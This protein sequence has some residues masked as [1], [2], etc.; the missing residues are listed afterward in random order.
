MKEIKPGHLLE[1]LAE[2]VSSMLIEVDGKKFV[3]ENLAGNFLFHVI[4]VELSK[5]VIPSYWEIPFLSLLYFS[6]G[7]IGR[8][9]K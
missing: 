3:A 5:S 7:L 6:K 2:D 1:G 4:L 9:E 8:H